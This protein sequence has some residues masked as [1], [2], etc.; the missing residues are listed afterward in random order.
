MTVSEANK[1]FEKA[2]K[3]LSLFSNIMILK[4]EDLENSAKQI[5][6]MLIS[7]EE[8]SL[9]DISDYV[10][11]SVYASKGEMINLNFTL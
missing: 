5:C 10:K 2:A 11:M 8:C 1:Y 7:R 9:N 4:S 3:E 6:E